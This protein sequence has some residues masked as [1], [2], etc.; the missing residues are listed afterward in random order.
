VEVA[1]HK[2]PIIKKDN[3]LVVVISDEE[4]DSEGQVVMKSFSPEVDT[5]RSFSPEVDE[6]AVAKMQ[7]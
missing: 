6:D 2:E 7:R 4:C 5:Y 3:D 1:P